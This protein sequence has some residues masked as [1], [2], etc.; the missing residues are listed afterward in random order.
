MILD[1]IPR[2]KAKE[3]LELDKGLTYF[4]LIEYDWLNDIMWFYYFSYEDGSRECM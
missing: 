2:A 1:K 3:C 4:L